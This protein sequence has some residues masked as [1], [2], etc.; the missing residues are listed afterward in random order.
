MMSAS[1]DMP[2]L[3]RFAEQVAGN[4]QAPAV[5]DQSVTLTYAEL[6]S[7]SERIARGLL[8]RGV[9]PGQRVALHFRVVRVRHVVQAEHRVHP[10]PQAHQVL[11]LVDRPLG[12]RQTERWHGGDPFRQLLHPVVQLGDGVTRLDELLVR[13]LR[14]ALR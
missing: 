1:K 3:A 10:G 8:A 6:A 13:E 9:E 5:I 11:A 14:S 4:P 7:A 2:L 12:Q